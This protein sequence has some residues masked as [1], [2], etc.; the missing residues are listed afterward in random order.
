[1][2]QAHEGVVDPGA[3]LGF[4]AEGVL[5]VL[6]RHLEGALA[7]VVVEGAPGTARKRVRA[8]QCLSM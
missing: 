6:D 5:A 4:V 7:N 3:P 1:V 2:D 8:V